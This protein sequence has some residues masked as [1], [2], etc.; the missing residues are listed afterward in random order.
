MGECLA[1]LSKMGTFANIKLLTCIIMKT[2]KQ[3]LKVVFSIFISF[4]YLNNNAN[5]QSQWPLYAIGNYC[6]IRI[7]ETLEVRDDNSFSG[8]FINGMKK[9]IIKDGVSQEEFV[10][11]PTGMNS[12]D[13]KLM[14]KA[15]SLYARIIIAYI[16]QNELTQQDVQCLTKEDIK[17]I[18]TVWKNEH[19]EI[20]EMMGASA[21]FVWYPLSRKAFG[22]KY[23]LVT[24]YDRGGLNGKVCVTEYKFFLKGYLLRFT[25]SYRESEKALWKDDFDKTMQTL[26]FN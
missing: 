4:F 23:A 18:N 11:Q 12:K 10:F 1:N 24:R 25:L 17:Q 2:N 15:N 3:L 5:A 21:D 14:R 22:N 13:L 20:M 9:L 8:R 7:P 19:S 16:K 26:S 6:S